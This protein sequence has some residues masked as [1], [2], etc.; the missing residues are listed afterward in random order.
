MRF[1]MPMSQPPHPI[2]APEVHGDSCQ[3]EASATPVQAP[4]RLHS[5]DVMRGHNAVAIEHNGH[6][7]RL[8]TTRQGK[9][10]LTK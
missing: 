10:I 2:R 1:D 4:P 9:L 6:L 7:Y 3:T 8:Q 5:H